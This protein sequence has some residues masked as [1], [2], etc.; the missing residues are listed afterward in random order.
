MFNVDGAAG[1]NRL[2]MEESLEIMI[3]FW[4]SEE[5]FEYKGKYW[6]VRRP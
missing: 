4:V 2:M 5:S 3:R 6:T 1:E